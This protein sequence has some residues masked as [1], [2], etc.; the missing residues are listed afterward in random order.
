LGGP[1]GTGTV[2][3]VTPAGVE[4]VL[5]AFDGKDGAYPSALLNVG[6]TLYG[7]AALG[8][9]YTQGT[10]FSITTS[11]TVATIYSFTKKDGVQQP[12][13]PLIEVGGTFYGVSAGPGAGAV[14]SV[15]PSGSMS[16]VYAFPKRKQSGADGFDPVGR[17]VSL[18]GTLYGVTE[19]GGGSSNCGFDMGCGTVFSVT[20]TGTETV[21]HAFE[22]GNDGNT[23]LAGLLNVGG[24][25]YGT[26]SGGGGGGGNGQG[27]VYSITP[28]GAES[29]LYAFQG[30][31]DGARA[32]GDLTKV[33]NTLY[34]TTQ[35][36][37]TGNGTVFTV[38]LK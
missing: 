12:S 6:G 20:P 32:A 29:V 21:L 22:G 24:T 31:S 1:G 37:G 30:G 8:G 26:T 23:P 34:G 35:Y 9:R 16:I 27:T 4:T 14:Y 13:G 10:V 38:T 11:G 15:T 28:A 19:Q 7:T 18:G 5:Y 17:L 25:L 33:K 3:S 2:F 36:G